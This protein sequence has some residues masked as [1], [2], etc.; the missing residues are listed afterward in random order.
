MLEQHLIS[1]QKQKFEG[2]REKRLDIERDLNELKAIY[3]HRIDE[4]R[5]QMDEQRK[6]VIAALEDEYEVQV[7][8]IIKRNDDKFNKITQF[9]RGIKEENMKNIQK[10]KKLVKEKKEN[11]RSY[12]K[13]LQKNKK[14]I[15]SRKKPREENEE[16]KKRKSE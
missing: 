9:F 14:D 4:L 15:E 3:G 16:R 10:N 8:N 11:E 6:S 5:N 13:T 2:W 7:N 1:Q 12:I